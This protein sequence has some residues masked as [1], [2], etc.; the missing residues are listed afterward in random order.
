MAAQNQSKSV[1]AK[2]SSDGTDAMRH[3]EAAVLAKMLERWD[4]DDRVELCWRA[5]YRS[6]VGRG[7]LPGS[8]SAGALASSRAAS[9]KK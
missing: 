5:L 8:G 7:T 6:W 4:E 1:V 3:K 2:M 9:S